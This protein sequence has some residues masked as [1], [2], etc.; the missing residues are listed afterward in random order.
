MGCVPIQPSLKV[1]QT[2]IPLTHTAAF[3]NLNP[4]IIHRCT[5]GHWGHRSDTEK[6]KLC[7]KNLR[8]VRRISSVLGS[9]VMNGVPEP[10]INT[11]TATE[12]ERFGCCRS[13]SN[14]P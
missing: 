2:Q 5:Q 7:P 8:K 10:L 1:K 4:L 3:L 11:L 14:P 12:R 13:V 6:L 9:S